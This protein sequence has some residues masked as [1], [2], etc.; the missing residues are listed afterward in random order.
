MGRDPAAVGLVDHRARGARPRARRPDARARPSRAGRGSWWKTASGCGPRRASRRSGTRRSPRSPCAR[1]ASH[2][3]IRAHQGRRL[4]PARGGHV[5]GDWSIRKPGLA[6]GG[7]AFEYENDNYPDVDDT[8]VVA[9][10]LHELG[11]RRGRDR[12]RRRLDR[13]DAVE[14]AAVGVPSTSTTTRCGSTRSR[15]ATSARSPTSRPPTS[16]PTRSRCSARSTR[17]RR[18]RA[19]PRSGSSPSR[20]TTARG[21]AAGAS[22]TS[23]ARAPRSPV[24]RRWASRPTT[25]RCAAPSRWLDSVQQE[26]G[27]FGEDIRSYADPAWRG[28]AEFTTASQTAWALLGYVAAGNAE[29]SDRAAGRQTISVPRSV[30]TVTGTSSISPARVFRSIS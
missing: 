14:R 25:R 11:H 12:P 22:T 6:P 20:R 8:A 28:R 29:A 18:R 5:K 13:G 21:S 30:P 15:S 27:G 26:N 3:T 24:S 17:T 2:P 19:R 10:T 4:S 23:T 1:A 16:R 7:W 9:L